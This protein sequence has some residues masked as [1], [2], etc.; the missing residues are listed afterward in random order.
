MKGRGH[1]HVVCEG[2][3]CKGGPG[4]RGPDGRCVGYRDLIRVC[5]EAP[6][7]GCEREC[8]PVVPA[9]ALKAL[10]RV[11]L[12]AL[13]ASERLSVTF[14]PADTPKRPAVAAPASTR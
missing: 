7:A 2:C 10:G 1:C 6:H 3:G 4:Y 5:G 12:K 11:W 9:C 14:Q 8:A 13:A